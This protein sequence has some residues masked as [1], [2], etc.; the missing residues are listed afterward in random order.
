MF[1][2]LG[3]LYYDDSVEKY[4]LSSYTLK[5]LKEQLFLINSKK[6]KGVYEPKSKSFIRQ[7]DYEIGLKVNRY[8]KDL[9]IFTNYCIANNK[10]FTSNSMSRY[11]T[12]IHNQ[13]NLARK[14]TGLKRKQK[15]NE[16]TEKYPNIIKMDKDA[17]FYY[18][19]KL[20]ELYNNAHLYSNIS[21]KLDDILMYLNK[22]VPDMEDVEEV[23]SNVGKEILEEVRYKQ[24][25]EK[26][27]E[28]KLDK[29]NISKDDYEF[30]DFYK[31]LLEHMKEVKEFIAPI[32]IEEF[33]EYIEFLND[34]D[35][36]K[37]HFEDMYNIQSASQHIEGCNEMLDYINQ[38]NYS[39]IH[40]RINKDIAKNEELEKQTELLKTQSINK[41]NIDEDMEEPF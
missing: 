21:D 23:L 28:T 24:S 17:K 38:F 29:M 8:L 1:V 39:S 11:I 40:N 14:T 2:F 6:E 19:T 37:K 10:N 27:L 13:L 26:E 3:V 12:S 34:T 5:E 33:Y 35:Q 7:I 4:N 18:I 20:T 32:T 15:I 36:M 25:Q 16:L 31:K 22:Y 30:N 41:Y 9:I